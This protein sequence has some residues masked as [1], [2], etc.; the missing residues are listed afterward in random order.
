M[1]TLL[2][3]ESS[4]HWKETSVWVLSA[5]TKQTMVTYH[6][7]IKKNLKSEKKKKRKKV[8][9]NGYKPIVLCS[10]TCLVLPSW[11]VSPAFGIQKDFLQTWILYLVWLV[12]W[13]CSV[14]WPAL[15]IYCVHDST[16]RTAVIG[17]LSSTS[18]W[19]LE[20]ED[21]KSLGASRNFRLR[22]T[23]KK[24]SDK[25]LTI[26]WGISRLLGQVRRRMG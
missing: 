1:L 20:V 15:S 7:D 23:F 12:C 16:R 3:H 4:A 10:T 19:Y 2:C 6:P 24:H 14:R 8:R 21:T 9:L 22:Y 5:S 26:M 17:R 11:M 13:V 18:S 25:Q